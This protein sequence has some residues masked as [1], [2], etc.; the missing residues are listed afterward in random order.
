MTIIY[1]TSN[2]ESTFFESLIRE[3]LIRSSRGLPIVSV[4]QKPIDL[5]KNICV[6]DVGAS[7]INTKRQILI[8]LKHAET[9]NVCMAESDF[10]YPPA[11][12]K[13]IPEEKDTVYYLDNLY[14]L[15][16]NRDRFHRKR[17][18]DGALVCNREYLIKRLSEALENAP[19]WFDGRNEPQ[20]KGKLKHNTILYDGKRKPFTTEVPAV[21]FKTGRG[22]SW[23]CPHSKYTY[24]TKLPYWGTAKSLN[25][26][27]HELV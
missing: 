3:E 12:F 2:R 7:N 11:Y 18:S 27:F 26:R 22:I 13:F 5:G 16:I 14:V 17:N 21:T 4:S 8:G 9:E 25:R 20:Y 1:Y 6:G 15:W 19:E 10:L 24:K 23:K